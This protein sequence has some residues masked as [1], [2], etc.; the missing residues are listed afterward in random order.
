MPKQAP[1]LQEGDILE[2]PGL[3]RLLT[4]DSNPSMKLVG[5]KQ[6]EEPE[7]SSTGRK[8]TTTKL[9]KGLGPAHDLNG[10]SSL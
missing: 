1:A 10:I 7:N 2:S 4:G 5:L 8:G 6:Q 9:A 3:L